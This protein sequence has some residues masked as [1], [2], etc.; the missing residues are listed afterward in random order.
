MVIYY[1]KNNLMLKRL[2]RAQL[3]RFKDFHTD[4][5]QITALTNFFN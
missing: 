4:F 2:K 1:L 3:K 5:Y